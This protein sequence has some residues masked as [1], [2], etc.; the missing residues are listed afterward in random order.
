MFGSANEW[1]RLSAIDMPK[2][3]EILHF[4]IQNHAEWMIWALVD[5]NAE[6]EQRWFTVV[7]TG[8]AWREDPAMGMRHVGTAQ[9]E[10]DGVEWVWHLFEGIPR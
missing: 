9:D 8:Q 5:P 2:G 1:N 3:A 10:H 6:I 4:G 7:G